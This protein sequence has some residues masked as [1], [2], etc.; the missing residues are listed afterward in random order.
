MKLTDNTISTHFDWWRFVAIDNPTSSS[1][2]RKRMG[3]RP[4]QRDLIQ[5]LEHGS[6]FDSRKRQRLQRLLAASRASLRRCP[7]KP[8]LPRLSCYTGEEQ[9]NE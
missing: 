8:R 5:D 7:S 3:W 9:H 4:A 1:L 6:Y 2:T